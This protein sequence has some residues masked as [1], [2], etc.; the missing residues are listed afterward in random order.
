MGAA[1]EVVLHEYHKLIEN[2]GRSVL[3]VCGLGGT[4]KTTICERVYALS[5]GSSSIFEIDW[6]LTHT[7][8]VR[9]ELVLESLSDPPKSAFWQNSTN[10]YD[11]SSLIADLIQ[12]KET[13]S[14][15]RQALWR[16]ATGEKDLTINIEIGMPGVKRRAKGGP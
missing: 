5:N 4:G 9:R 6:Y 8:K 16:Q 2:D 3:G 1:L 12:L 14:L 10:W 11:W 13:G 7:R 15:S